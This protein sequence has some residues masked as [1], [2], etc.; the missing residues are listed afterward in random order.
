MYA[1]NSLKLIG[2]RFGK[3]VVLKRV[4]NVVYSGKKQS[5]WLRKCDCGN[6]KLITGRSL[7]EG[8][9]QSCGCLQKERASNSNLDNLTGLSFG[10][11]IVLDRG[12]D[13]VSPK[14]QH[15]RRWIVK[16]SCGSNPFLTTAGSLKNGDTTSCG[17]LSES[18]VANKLKKYFSRNYNA[19]IEYKIFK[20]PFTGWYL[21][22]DIYIP[23]GINPSI[24]GIYVE[25]HGK[26]H[27]EIR[28]WHKNLAKKNNTSSKEEFERQKHRDKLKKKFAKKNGT[29]IMIDLRKIKSVDDAIK[30][31]EDI[32]KTL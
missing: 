21:P 14:G 1:H 7:L 15:Q 5:C 18:W 22:Y 4:E 19:E 25:V 32:L 8:H 31:V 29:Y 13:Y 17:C 12:E 30:Y 2:M 9:T 3:L 26:Q 27:F 6:E 11:L 16:C 24:T 23:Y 28:D 10:N 20:N